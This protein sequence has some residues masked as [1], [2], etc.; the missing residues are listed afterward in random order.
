[1][2][3]KFL[4][5]KR[6][7]IKE[8]MKQLGIASEKI[9]FVVDKNK[10]LLGT[11]T[12]GDIRRWI[13]KK[14]NLQEAVTK[15][16]NKEPDYIT[17]GDYTISKAR[18]LMIGRNIESLPMV[19]KNKVIVDVLFWKDLLDEK[20]RRENK[21]LSVPVVIMA[22][23]QGKRMD[24]FTRILPKP[25]IPVG[26]K[27][28]LELVMDHFYENG[29]SEFF[30]ILGYKGEM[31]ASY[32]NNSNKS[33]V[34]YKI[35]YIWEKKPLGTAGGLRAL[36]KDFSKS[37]FLSNCDTIIKANYSDMYKFHIVNKHQITMVASVKHFALPYG[38]V[39]LYREKLKRVIEKPEYDFL[40]N[41]GMYILQ[42]DTINLIPKNKVFHI[43]DLI[44]AVKDKKGKV[45]IYPVNE[46]SWLDIGEWE[47]Y[48]EAIKNFEI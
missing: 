29:C 12:D 15:I 3:K 34:T 27:P 13:L 23:G 21:R 25:L 42:K 16:Y 32:F 41:T 6:I 44:K 26:E 40:V 47:K 45:G 46:K 28:A 31:I 5:S 4:V 9:L 7:T 1:M 14:G 19:N 36:L 18:D 37:F 8:A 33:N 10:R 17:K 30:L 48:K 35:N 20:H 38:V 11:I 39:E 22:G 43:T 24:P 2:I